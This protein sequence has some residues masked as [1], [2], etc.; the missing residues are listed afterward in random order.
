MFK[1]IIHL[2]SLTL[3]VSCNKKMLPK[4][5]EKSLDELQ[6]NSAYLKFELDVFDNKY[7]YSG[8]EL[9]KISVAGDTIAIFN[10]RGTS[11]ITSVSVSNPNKIIVFSK[12][13]QKSWTLD[14]NLAIIE[15]KMIDLIDLGEV[16]IMTRLQ[17]DDILYYS[18]SNKKFYR[19]NSNTLKIIESDVQWDIEN[20]IV[21]LISSDE[22]FVVKTTSAE[23]FLYD[24]FGNKL[25]AINIPFKSAQF[26]F[27]NGIIYQIRDDKLY[28]IDVNDPIAEVN[29]QS[30]PK[31]F[32]SFTDFKITSK[33]LYLLSKE[34]II[35][36]PLK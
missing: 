6:D 23:V 12:D 34:E 28:A 24:G 18:K 29:I 10:T 19:T 35:K 3:L 8:L 27:L 9:M 20:D 4:S 11:T 5:L 30:L 25:K 15:D 17:G 2:I 22:L 13:N 36:C 33:N 21:K 1:L 32:N 31:A 16:T 7:I 26:D 14:S